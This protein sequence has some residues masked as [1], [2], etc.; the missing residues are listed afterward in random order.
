MLGHE[1]H[2]DKL[3]VSKYLDSKTLFISFLRGIKPSSVLV[4]NMWPLLGGHTRRNQTFP[5]GSSFCSHH[6]A[7]SRHMFML[8]H[9]LGAFWVSHKYF[10]YSLFC[11]AV[12]G[13]SL[14]NETYWHETFRFKLKAALWYPT[15]NPMNEL[16]LLNR[17]I[18]VNN[19][20][21]R[22][23]NTV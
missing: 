20:I 4:S 11:N 21:D 6:G 13:F 3:W 9:H 14:P 19:K 8:L 10:T 7:V 23:M 12:M 1:L 16:F 5:L 15:I 22:I 18:I 2:M 17:D